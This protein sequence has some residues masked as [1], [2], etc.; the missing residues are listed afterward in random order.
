MNPREGLIVEGA[1]HRM[2]VGGNEGKGHCSVGEFWRDDDD[3]DWLSELDEFPLS[4]PLS[5][6]VDE[7]P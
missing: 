7:C 6:S 2:C 5:S 1:G 3:S 4:R